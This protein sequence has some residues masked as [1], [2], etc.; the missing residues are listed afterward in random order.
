MAR[1]TFEPVFEEDESVIRDRIIARIPDTWRKEP[2]DFMYDAVA[3]VPAEIKELQVAQDTLLKDMHAQYAEGPEMDYLLAEVGLTRLLATRNKR[4]LQVVA[5]PGVTI[6]AG[7]RAVA[8]VT[9]T[10]GNPLEFTVDTTT[11]FGTINML[12]VTIT[13]VVAGTESNL[14][15][16]SEF[17]LVPPIAGVRSIYDLGTTV[18]GTDTETDEAAFERYDFRVKNP[19]TGGNKNDFKRWAMEVEGVGNAKVI[20]RWNGNGTV[21]VLLV[22]PESLPVSTTVATN[23]QS[24]IDPDGA[25]MG[26]GKAP[27][28]AAT[29]VQPALNL[30]INITANVVFTAGADGVAVKTLFEKNLKEYLKSI[31]FTEPQEPVVYNRIGAMFFSTPGIS[32]YTDLLVNGGMADIMPGLEEVAT[33]G[34]VAF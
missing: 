25:G 22:D 16:G 26:E 30:P 18:L 1:P 10:E 20:P 28:G 32:N 17:S 31:A 29:I 19:D 11:T 9:D 7:H 14:A 3:A 13:A 23:A 33:P 34:V 6:P 27:A 21:K 8:I 15:T 2:G 5:D 12:N 24:Y 4:T